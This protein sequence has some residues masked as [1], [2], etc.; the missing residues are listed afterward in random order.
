[1]C[2]SRQK[3][4]CT[5]LGSWEDRRVVERRDRLYALFPA[6]GEV[7]KELVLKGAKSL[8]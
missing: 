6:T 2:V 5:A 7:S 1:M 8:E 3:Q 4:R